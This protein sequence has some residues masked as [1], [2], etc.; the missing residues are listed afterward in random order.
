VI[1]EEED[2]VSKDSDLWKG[3]LTLYGQGQVG[4]W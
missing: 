3:G 1:C 4:L 2:Y